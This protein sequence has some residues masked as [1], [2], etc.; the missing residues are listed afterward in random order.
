[1]PPADEHVR[2]EDD[3]EPGIDVA[4]VIARAIRGWS[5]KAEVAGMSSI[6][7]AEYA[8]Q[9]SPLHPRLLN[10]YNATITHL[11]RALTIG[12]QRGE[13][14]SDINPRLKAIEMIAFINGLETAWLVDRSIAVE[15]VAA[16]WVID[17]ERAL[18]PA[19]GG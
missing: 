8:G 11:S 1:V 15:S 19:S 18:R 16:Q 17:Q 7:I 5:G 4:N 14:R 3:E 6:L 10:R 2:W 9:D 12:Q 13:I